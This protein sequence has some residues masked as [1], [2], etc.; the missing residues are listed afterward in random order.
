M[1]QT[2]RFLTRSNGYNRLPNSHWQPSYFYRIYKGSATQLR[3]RLFPEIAAARWRRYVTAD[4]PSSQYQPPPPRA[5]VSCEPHGIPPGLSRTADPTRCP[6][7]AN[8]SYSS[9]RAPETAAWSRDWRSEFLR[10]AWWLRACE[11]V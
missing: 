9:P 11:L 2:V 3:V 1:N 4:A 7:R 8:A 5:R 10:R 6:A